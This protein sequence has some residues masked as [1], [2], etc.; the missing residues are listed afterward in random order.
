MEDK[1]EVHRNPR[2][3]VLRL[4]LMVRFGLIGGGMIVK[5]HKRLDL[6]W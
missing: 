2:L 3:V 1:H 4:N 5:M 6:E